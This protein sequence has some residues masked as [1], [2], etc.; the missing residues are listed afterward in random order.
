M[1]C[2]SFWLKDTFSKVVFFLGRKMFFGVGKG[3]F[4]FFIGFSSRLSGDVLVIR[5]F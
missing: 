2:V 5:G 4:E 1:V 3:R